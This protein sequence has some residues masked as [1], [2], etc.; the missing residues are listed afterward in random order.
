MQY[1][2]LLKG[3]SDTPNSRLFTQNDK[4][5]ARRSPKEFLFVHHRILLPLTLEFYLTFRTVEVE[6][7]AF[8][9]ARK[10][11]GDFTKTLDYKDV[12]AVIVKDDSL[13][14]SFKTLYT[15][16]TFTSNDIEPKYSVVKK[17]CVEHIQEAFGRNRKLHKRARFEQR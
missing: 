7:F 17:D 10:Y 16:C 13:R 1:H 12:E 2:K 3:G 6:H 14:T 9:F 8:E 5:K 15:S 4:S 11:T